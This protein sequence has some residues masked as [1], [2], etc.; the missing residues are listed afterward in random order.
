MIELL[1][2]TVTPET[3]NPKAPAHSPTTKTIPSDNK[4]L[5]RRAS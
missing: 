1:M 5:M 3:T 2:E 4:L